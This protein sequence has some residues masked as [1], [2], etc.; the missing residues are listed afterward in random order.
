MKQKLDFI[1]DPNLVL[2]LPLHE[3]DS[4]SFASKDAYG[5]LVTCTGALWRPNGRL[6]NGTS[7]FISRAVADWRSADQQGTIIAWFKCPADTTDRALF[8][9]SDEATTVYYLNFFVR[10]THKLGISQVNND[11]ADG[12]AGGTDVDDD[13]W[14]M[15]ALVSNGSAY[16]IF[17]DANE[18]TLTVFSGVNSGDWFADTASRDN[19]AVGVLKRTSLVCYL[20]GNV[21]EVIVYSRA[22][23]P[24]EIQRNYLAT[25]WRYR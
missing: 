1:Y 16:R 10:G 25:K 11:T 18:E 2:Y 19:F 24:L 4:S 7:D 22:L 3:L 20:T 8:T 13:V 14:H 5:H 15:G 6:F 21:G 23:T 12:V 9:S 17:S